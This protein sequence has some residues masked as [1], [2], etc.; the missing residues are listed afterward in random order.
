MRR[1]ALASSL[2]P[3]VK[4]NRSMG[5]LRSAILRLP[6]G[7]C[8]SVYRR[9]DSLAI[10]SGVHCDIDEI[11]VEVEVPGVRDGRPGDRT[12]IK[13]GQPPRIRVRRSPHSGSWPSSTED[14]CAYE[15]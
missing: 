5:N 9:G 7:A 8:S 4:A 2:W 10:G 6:H 12:L 13:R 3:E 1:A 11:E 15:T 14:P